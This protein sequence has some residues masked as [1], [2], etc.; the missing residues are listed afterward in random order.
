MAITESD[1]AGRFTIPTPKGIHQAA[2]DTNVSTNYA[3]RAENIRTERGLLA[4]GYGT[5]RAFP[6]L[7]A[8]IETLTQFYRRTRPD[9]ADVFV[10]AANGSIY[11][12]TMGTEGW[13]KRA[14][15]FLSNRWSYVTYEVT[16]GEAAEGGATTGGATT[17][18]AT[19][20][21][22]IMSNAKDGMIAVYGSDLRVE[23]KALAI[24][25]DYAGVKFAVL[26]R[27]A[28]RIW[29]AGAEG[30]PDS[31]FYSRPY[32]PFTWTGISETPELGGGVI[33]QPTWDGDSFIALAQFGGYL[34]AMKP[35]TIF[36]IRGTDPGSF[37]I[38]EAYG[39][40]GALCAQTIGV[41]RLQMIY[42]AR[43]GLGNYDGS[44]L[45]LLSRDALYETMRLRMPGTEEK[46]TACV[47][48]H[49]YYLALCVRERGGDVISENN[50]VI[51]YDTERGTFMLRTG[52]RVKDFF[53][54]G[55]EIYYTDA[56]AP[57]DVYRYG[58]PESGS[59]LGTPIDSVWETGWLD[60]GKEIL[61]RDF[62]L[63]FTADA[64]QNDVP[65]EI[66]LMTNRREKTKVVLLQKERRDYRVKIQLSGVRVRLRIRGHAR[67]AGW[68]IY[69]GVQ[70]DYTVD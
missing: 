3:Y 5:S 51:E 14:E 46:A 58:D 26:C 10:A 69:G 57:Y 40:D 22:L 65:L 20:D 67:A 39:T 44:T 45:S 59:Y 43:G 24:G 62:V 27:H 12:Y 30:Y 15:G 18:G 41:D 17:G 28:E 52:I 55:G 68:R 36:E 11:T 63:R 61:K 66:S 50:T 6:S 2:G 60:L 23:R 42:L 4:S 29:G 31:V 19:V 13:V 21:V 48:D 7:G 53:A 32:D 1:Y 47:S 70:V 64:D 8:P 25:E 37:T 35:S 33:D 38:S 49:V 34:L 9:D 54:L 56:L 16:A